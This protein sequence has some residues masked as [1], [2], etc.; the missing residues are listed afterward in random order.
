MIRT[1]HVALPRLARNRPITASPPETDAAEL[2]TDHAE[3]SIGVE[4]C[5]ATGPAGAALALLT[6]VS[7]SIEPLGPVIATFGMLP[8]IVVV[9]MLLAMPF[10]GQFRRRS[11]DPFTPA[12]YPVWT[13]LAPVFVGGSL[14]LWSGW[15]HQ[16]MRDGLLPEPA[17]TFYCLAMAY[18]AV[19]WGSLL[20]G[21]YSRLGRSIGAR[22]ETWL[23]RVD[24]GPTEL[25][26][27]AAVLLLIGIGCTVAAYR[28]GL[29]GYQRQEAAGPYD[30]LLVYAAGLASLAAF[31]LWHSLFAVRRWTTR[32][33]ALAAFL[34]LLAPTYLVVTASRAALL[35]YLFVLAAAYRFAGRPINRRSIAAFVLMG[36]FSL[37]AGTAWSTT[38]RAIK[39]SEAPISATAAAPTSE[40]LR[41]TVRA[42]GERGLT[43]TAAFIANNLGQRIE[44]T[45]SLAVVVANYRR[46][47]RQEEESG[48]A[49]NIWRETWTAFV[50]RALWPGK[51]VVSD[52]RTYSDVYFGSGET[53][54]AITPMGDLLRNFGP[55]GIPFG[56]ALLGCGLRAS[57]RSLVASQ[58]LRTP[59]VALYTAVL[60]TV[61]Y[62]AFYGTIMPTVL[63]VC[64][65]SVA[66]LL[67]VHMGVSLE[68]RLAG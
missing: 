6:A 9:G 40:L 18:A 28:T 26:R 63:R 22:V 3:L 15:T 57:Y 42:S 19:G 44:I 67:V 39:G 41:D 46:L 11:L 53:S 45:S 4:P 30:A 12:T 10:A 31:L 35:T 24:W 25:R 68:R 7:L 23:P 1:R 52:A 21:Y 60:M 8:L 34:I 27:P 58:P 47:Q 5:L 50:P 37:S 56:M 43:G 48:I 32:E 51:P 13:Y 29:I 65:L 55:I 61:S 33:R 38:Y 54:F 59:R 16:A 2:P 66:G 20:I 64:V 17:T 36:A 49:G 62:E 14:I